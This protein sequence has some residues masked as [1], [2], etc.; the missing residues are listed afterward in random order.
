M[1]SQFS[2]TEKRVGFA[3]DTVD[4][5]SEEGMRGKRSGKH[6]SGLSRQVD[7]IDKMLDDMEDDLSS[8]EETESGTLHQTPA[9]VRT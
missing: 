9:M 3:D 5:S 4:S 7:D 2:I 8:D 1:R 6:S